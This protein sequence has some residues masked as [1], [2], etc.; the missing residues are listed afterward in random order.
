MPLFNQ[1]QI[2]APVGLVIWESL[3]HVR[4]NGWRRMSGTALPT[5]KL[6]SNHDDRNLYN[7]RPNGLLYVREQ[8]VLLYKL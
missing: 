6:C 4:S 1:K 7:N 5:H 2:D 3:P 8:P